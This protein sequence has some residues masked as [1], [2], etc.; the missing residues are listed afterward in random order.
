MA[1][2]TS[3]IT[4][5]AGGTAQAVLAI[6]VSGAPIGS[7]SVTITGTSGALSHSTAITVQVTGSGGGC[8]IATAT[9]GSEISEEVQFLRTFRDNSIMK[10]SSGS[11]FMVAFNAWYYSFSPTVAEFI[12]AHS[13]AKAVTK[14][15][16]YPLIGIL[17]LGA[18]VFHLSP[19]NLEAGAVISGLLVSSIIGVVYLTPPLVTALALS[20][21][22]RRIAKRLQLPITM[23][24]ISALAAVAL[25]MILGAPELLIMLATSAIVL[26]SL[27]AS[28]L[29]ASRA[30]LYAETPL[31]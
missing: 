20:S 9:Y 27:I 6:T 19:A 25:A 24:L 7:H 23:V 12:R 18:A 31:Q 29:I 3:P 10:T 2:D 4:P 16:L 26:S 14:V 11:N 17:R 30:I 5:L 1:F 15:M 22:V 13:A 8:L 28:G 21:K